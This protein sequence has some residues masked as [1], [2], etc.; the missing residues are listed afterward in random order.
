MSR[1]AG[2]VSSFRMVE[3]S[4]LPQNIVRTIREKTIHHVGNPCSDFGVSWVWGRHCRCLWALVW[5]FQRLERI[6]LGR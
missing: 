4:I 6:G 2:L 1:F 5:R 3:S